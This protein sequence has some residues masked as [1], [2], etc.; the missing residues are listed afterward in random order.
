MALRIISLIFLDLSLQLLNLPLW[1]HFMFES[2]VFLGKFSLSFEE[3]KLFSSH[4]DEVTVV[5]GS[6]GVFGGQSRQFQIGD[7]QT[8]L[9]TF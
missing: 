3:R 9:I 4:T 5:K 6:L 2:P 8:L 1:D 7:Q